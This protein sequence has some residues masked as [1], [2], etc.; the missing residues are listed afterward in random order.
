MNWDVVGTIADVAAAIAV[1][2]S[3]VYLAHQIR[4]QT[5]SAQAESIKGN[6]EGDAAMLQCWQWL[7]IQS[8]PKYMLRLF[9]VFQI[10]NQP[11]RLDSHIHLA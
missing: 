11:S 8:W 6:V 10:L 2:A 7:R 1:I 3:V 9:P 4:Q 5:R